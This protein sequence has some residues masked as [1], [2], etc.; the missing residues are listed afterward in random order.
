LQHFRVPELLSTREPGVHTYEDFFTG[1]LLSLGLSV[2]PADQPDN[3]E[4]HA[5]D[6]VYFVIAGR[7]RIRVGDED[8]PV[9]AGS[10]VFVPTG[11]VHCF[12]RI[13]EVLKVLVFWAPPHHSPART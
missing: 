2:W 10:I 6:E 4:P 13:E 5:E 7:G 12:H 1:E 8:E 9:E 3:Q 11:V